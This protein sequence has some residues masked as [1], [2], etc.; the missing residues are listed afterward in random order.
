MGDGCRFQPLIFE[1]MNPI[2]VAKKIVPFGR[3]KT[4]FELGIVLIP[5][6]MKGILIKD[7]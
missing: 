7:V 2:Q 3:R 4:T 1:G 5:P 6:F